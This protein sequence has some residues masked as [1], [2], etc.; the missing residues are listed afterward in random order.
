MVAWDMVCSPKLLGGLGLKN[1]KLFNV[2]LRMRWRWLELAEE[3]KPWHGLE[4]D[5]PEEAEAL[6]KAAA[7]CVL[8]DGTKLN[9]WTDRWLGSCSIAELAPNLMKFVRPARR[10]DSVGVALTK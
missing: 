5:I 6:F 4:F 2:A 1:L 3:E 7:M 10:N 9:F 8:G